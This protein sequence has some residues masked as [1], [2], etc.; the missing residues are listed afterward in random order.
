MTPR[1]RAAVRPA[2]AA[3]IAGRLLRHAVPDLPEMS[4]PG[5]ETLRYTV[6]WAGPVDADLPD[7]RAV[8]AACGLMQVHGRATGGPLPLAVDYA[9]VVAGVLAAQGAT[10][11]RVARARGLG[12]REVRTSVAQGALLAVGQYLAAETA[13]DNSGSPEPGAPHAPVAASDVP[14]AGGLATLETADDARVEVETLD[15]LAWREFWARLGVAPALAGRGWLPFQ[16]RFATAV[17]PLPDELRQVARRR[18]LAELRAA[19]HHTGVSLLAVGSDPAPAVRPAPWCLTPGPAPFPDARAHPDTA[20]PSPRPAAPVSGAVLPLTGLRV[21]EST[22]RVQGPLAGHVLRMLGAEVVR[23][24]PPGGDPMRWLPP[25]AGDCSARFSALNAGKPV[26]EA[27]LTAGQGRDTV[28]ALAAEA[29]VFLHNWAPGKAAGLG[30]DASDLLPGHP[31]LVYAWA[32]GFGDAFGGRPPLGT[33]YLAQV[34]SGLAAAV[35]PTD[36]PPAPSLMTLTDVLGGLVCAQGV[37]A[38]L[39]ARE[40]TGRGSRVDSSLVSAAALVPRPAHRP[41]WTALDRPLRTADGQLYLGPEARAC[42]E[43]VL[44]LLD[45][46]G[47][48]AT[49]DL[50]ARFA[51]RTTE[52]WTARLAEAG[53]TATP[54][55]TDLT[56]LAHDPAFRAAVAPPDPST[57]HAR[58]YA[59]WEFA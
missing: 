3:A 6:A 20:V 17:C 39:A 28:R 49:E 32:S 5:R 54:V 48:M 42:P 26:V 58:P 31:A 57:G 36:Q 37:L 35:R 13:R 23:I 29:D 34:H 44:R 53:L 50:T 16:Q 47:P 46:A 18:T 56:A 8:Q 2:V 51:R 33:D 11:L 14:Q 55:L 25:L 43:A 30:L 41:R 22:R 9:S 4:G 27:D 12:L 52:E 15:P 40:A 19:A 1:L 45:G 10:A 7:E 21:V 24:E 38:A 59:P